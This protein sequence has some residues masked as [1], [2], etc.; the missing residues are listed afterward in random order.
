MADPT[1]FRERGF[2]GL[3]QLLMEEDDFGEEMAAYAAA[4]RRM[5]RRLDRWDKAQHL[6]LGVIGTKRIPPKGDPN[7]TIIHEG[8]DSEDEKPRKVSVKRPGVNGNGKVSMRE[9]DDLDDVDKAL[10]GLEGQSE[11]EE[12]GENEV[13]EDDDLDDV[14]KALL[15]LRGDETEDEG[16]G[17]G[18]ES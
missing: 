13:A 8:E 14:D 11:G 1:P 17:S 15:G 3:I 18:M 7:A 12:D 5:G 6:N 10:L 4:F 16:E 2:G 9:E